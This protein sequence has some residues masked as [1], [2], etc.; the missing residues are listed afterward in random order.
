MV[1]VQEHD[2]IYIG[3]D[4]RHCTRRGCFSARFL[5]RSAQSSRNA[6]WSP[7]SRNLH[8]RAVNAFSRKPLLKLKITVSPPVRLGHLQ[9]L[10]IYIKIALSPLQEQKKKKKNDR[11]QIFYNETG[12]MTQGP[13]KK[14]EI[15]EEKFVIR[16]TCLD[17]IVPYLNPF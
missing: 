11:D 16:E 8:R 12:S 2:N 17:P 4:L 9:L 3:L 7:F 5:Q 15:G 13:R 1:F 14:K 10:Y 6:R